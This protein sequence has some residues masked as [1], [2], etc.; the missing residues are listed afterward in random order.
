[1]MGVDFRGITREPCIHPGCTC[2]DF[3]RSP[4]SSKCSDCSHPP[5]N[6]KALDSFQQTGASGDK[7]TRSDI[8]P[9]NSDS[10]L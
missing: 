10:E 2:T 5:T 9:H 8:T 6:H 4:G 3:Q 1:M 7:L